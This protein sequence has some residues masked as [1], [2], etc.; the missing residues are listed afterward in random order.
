MAVNRGKS[1]RAG[2]ALECGAIPRSKFVASCR[3]MGSTDP[4]LLI[5]LFVGACTLISVL[6][7]VLTWSAS[8]AKK[9]RLFEDQVVS[10]VRGMRERADQVETKLAEWQVTITGVLAEAE[11]FFDRSVKERKR[12]Q[13]AVA[14]EHAATPAT[15]PLQS[16]SRADQV[17]AVRASFAD[18]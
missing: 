9:V 8:R 13:A 14:R 18:Q 2:Y 7:C 1:P 4:Q 3:G 10:A 11:E 16:L 12:S 17:A 6:A 5:F 15:M